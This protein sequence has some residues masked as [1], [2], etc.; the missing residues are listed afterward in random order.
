MLPWLKAGD[1][2][3]RTVFQ[4]SSVWPVNRLLP[5]KNCIA[6]PYF[7]SQL[8]NHNN[9]CNNCILH[10]KVE[11]WRLKA[12]ACRV[13]EWTP[14]PCHKISSITKRS[15]PVFCQYLTN[16]IIKLFCDQAFNLEAWRD[17]ASSFSRISDWF[18]D[19]SESD[20]T[21][22]QSLSLNRV[23]STLE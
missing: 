9:S 18:R 17:S 14:G 23:Y 21:Q 5:P 12:V 15:Q 8:I 20:L 2:A 22:I 11:E 7:M 10:F 13:N 6:A 1:T 19:Q 4:C 16:Q 3:L